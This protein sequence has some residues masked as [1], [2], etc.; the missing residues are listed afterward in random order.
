MAETTTQAPPG[1]KPN[2]RCGA[3]AGNRNA[4]RPVP[5]LSMR[6]KDWKRRAKAAIRA[7]EG[8]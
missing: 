1:K 4:A 3:P 8:R 7:V 5:A 2:W 6:I